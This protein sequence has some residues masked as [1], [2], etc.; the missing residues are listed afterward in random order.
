MPAHNEASM[1]AASVDAVA[2]GLRA[3]GEEFE[4]IVVENGSSDAT[5]LIAADL[6]DHD[7][8]V[9]VRSLALA[10]YGAAI[11]EGIVRARG[12]LVVLFDVDYYDLD[13]LERAVARLRAPA[14]GD[15]PAAIVV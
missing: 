2:T 14:P 8:A 10:D 1:V 4:I 6:A 11:L 12:D 13:F 9:L 3:R 7:P 15:A 5:A